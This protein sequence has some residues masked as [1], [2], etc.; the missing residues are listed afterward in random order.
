M[1]KRGSSKAEYMRVTDNYLLN[2]L[3]SNFILRMGACSITKW[4]Y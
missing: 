4:S 3:I 1:I 2:D